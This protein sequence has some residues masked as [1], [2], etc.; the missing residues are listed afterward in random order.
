MRVRRHGVNG[1]SLPTRLE[2][3]EAEV[4]ARCVELTAMVPG[5][6]LGAV[7]DHE[8]TVPLAAM[9][10]VDSDALNRVIALGI[11]SSCGKV[12]VARLVA[13]F[14]RLEQGCF[15]V[16]VAPIA[17]PAV[18][19]HW[20]Q[21]AGLLLSPE[22]VTKVWRDRDDFDLTVTDLDVRRMT[23]LDADEVAQLNVR[24]WGAWQTQQSLR[25]WFAATV[26]Q[27]GFHHYGA[28]VDD[29]LVS[30]GALVVDGDLAWIGFD[31][32]HP[33]YALLGLRR[34]LTVRRLADARSTGCRYAHAETR[35]GF[36]KSR[37]SLFD[38]LYVRRVFTHGGR[39]HDDSTHSRAA[40]ARDR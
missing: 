10:A 12:A 22:T 39:S 18:I 6:P 24:A 37:E 16:E 29:R 3:H 30:C 26:G 1:A 40:D 31:A 21:G 19:G 11:A 25:P 28:F 4:W 5:N 33:R 38:T 9:T 36:G 20:L 15:R 17:A 13:F 34:S 35:L 23:A 32:T 2:L 27:D 7:V 8:G 14:E